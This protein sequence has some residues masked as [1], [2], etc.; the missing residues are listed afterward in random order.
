MRFSRAAQINDYRTAV[1]HR[2]LKS[3]KYIYFT[4]YLMKKS[5]EKVIDRQIMEAGAYIKMPRIIP[6]PIRATQPTAAKSILFQTS[7]LFST[8]RLLL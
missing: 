4:K 5:S 6:A 1:S 3:Q 7:L 2:L 8:L